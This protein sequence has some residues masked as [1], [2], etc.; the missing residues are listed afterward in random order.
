[1]RVSFSLTTDREDVRRWYEPHCASLDE[2]FQAMRDLLGEG[3]DV[4]ATL[5]PILPCNPEALAEKSLSCSSGDMVADP[6]HSRA[7]KPGGATTFP[8][9]ERISEVRGFGEWHQIEFQAAVLAR[10]AKIVESAGRRFG[11]GPRAF[12]W[13]STPRTT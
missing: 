1:L 10:L 13:L 12:A 2:R 3:I 4:W 9:A 7:N 11:A 8:P 6:L 5:A